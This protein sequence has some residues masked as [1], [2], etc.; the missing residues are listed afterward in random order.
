M[1]GCQTDRAVTG[2]IS[3]A[4]TALAAPRLV[5]PA[6]SLS[7]GRRDDIAGATPRLFDM[8]IMFMH[9]ILA[10]GIASGFLFS[11]GS[12]FADEALFKKSN[13]MACHAVDQ[14]RVGP[15]LKNIAAKYGGESGAAE[16]LAK[17]IKAGGAG[18]WG[19][20]PMPPQSQL[21]D[22]D[23]KALAEYV[24]SIK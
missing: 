2:E 10:I 23:A 11:T 14:T 9:N 13:C 22:A 6:C 8:R 19:Q 5:T 12:A 21:S 16:R 20:M 24:L 15:A 18:V 7:D 17:K 3:F 4:G 1:P